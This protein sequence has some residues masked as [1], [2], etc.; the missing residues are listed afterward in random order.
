MDCS[1][2]TLLIFAS[3]VWA[4]SSSRSGEES[5]D[6]VGSSCSG[7]G[8]GLRRGEK[9]ASG[10]GL[11]RGEKRASGAGL[12]RGEKRASGPGL[13]GGLDPMGGEQHCIY[14]NKFTINKSFQSS[15]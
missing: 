1:L 14:G 10:P 2:A 15:K 3:K 5:R 12:R 13:L 8:S 11:R 4:R 9:R 7:A 6:E